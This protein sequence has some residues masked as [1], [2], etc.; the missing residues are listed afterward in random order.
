MKVTEMENELTKAKD[1][2]RKFQSQLQETRHQLSLAQDKYGKKAGEKKGGKKARKKVWKIGG[3]K[4]QKGQEKRKKNKKMK[5]K[6]ENPD[7]LQ[8]FNIKNRFKN[9]EDTFNMSMRAEHADVEQLRAEL[10]E[11]ST[12]LAILQSNQQCIPPPPLFFFLFFFLSFSFFFL[13]S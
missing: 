7:F 3:K 11:K 9:T 4:K 8:N 5:K 1:E 2:Y 13:L 10:R 12:S 6:K